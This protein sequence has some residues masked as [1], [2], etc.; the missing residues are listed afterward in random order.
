MEKLKYLILAI[1]VT[2]LV[3]CVTK[4]RISTETNDVAVPILV[5]PPVID[6]PILEIDDMEG[7]NHLDPIH[8]EI[9]AKKIAI[10]I[11]QLQ[12]HI[13]KLEKTLDAYRKEL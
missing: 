7:L 12:A 2:L 6:R 3:S 11:V 4:T 8:R 13:E 9:I 10:S 1:S 5:E